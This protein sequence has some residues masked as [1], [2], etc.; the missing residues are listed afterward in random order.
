[1]DLHKNIT[2]AMAQS[3]DGNLERNLQF[4]SVKSAKF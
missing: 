4:L 3:D 1:M 2:Q